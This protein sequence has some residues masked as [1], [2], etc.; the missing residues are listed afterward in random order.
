VYSHTLL[1][2]GR[3]RMRRETIL[4]QMLAWFST[5]T[6]DAV[7]ATTTTAAFHQ[8]GST[9]KATTL[10]DS[11]NKR[12]VFLRHGCTYMNEYLGHGPSFG[13]PDFSDIFSA[14]EQH[15]Y[16]DSPLSPRGVQ[17]AE[18]LG[19]Q[20]SR[21]TF[22]QNLDLV[23]TSPL[24]RALQ[25]FELGVRPHLLDET[26][27]VMALPHCA[28]RLY[29]I[30]DQGRPVTEL[31]QEFDSV[32]F[33]SGFEGHDEAA[34]A[35]WYQHHK[36]DRYAEW[37]PTGRGQRYACPGEPDHAF[38]AR[39]I[40]LYDWLKDRPES[41]IAVVCHWGVIDYLLHMDFD[42]C[43]WCETAFNEIQPPSMQQAKRQR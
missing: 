34:A 30:S 29:L 41:K 9:A 10:L 18:Q 27:P 33:V 5:T 8:A 14:N 6:V 13:E 36:D 39:M 40:K 21:P 35:W 11:D 15:K 2:V 42:N 28:E 23:V 4:V 25:T 24:T 22:C 1:V 3:E 20:R 7:R 16:R 12:I 19:Q 17:Q 38:E 31:Q 37:R 26:V 43:E 32:D